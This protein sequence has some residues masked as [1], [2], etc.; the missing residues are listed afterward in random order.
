MS[1]LGEVPPAQSPGCKVD[2]GADGT[3]ALITNYRRYGGP[4]TGRWEEPGSLKVRLTLGQKAPLLPSS[5]L[6][7]RRREPVT[8][9]G[10]WPLPSPSAAADRGGSP[11]LMCM[12]AGGA[13]QLVPREL[14][15]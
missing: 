15:R 1:V 4:G 10:A 2:P 5:R 9:R 13:G 11:R 8:L 14:R 7:G 12:Q 6:R 3:L